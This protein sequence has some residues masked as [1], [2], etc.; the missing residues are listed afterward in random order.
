[1]DTRTHDF[2]EAN[3]KHFNETASDY[4][5]S[6]SSSEL[7]RRIARAVLRRETFDDETTEVMDFAC[8]PGL[9][10]QQLAPHVKSIVGVDISQGMTDIYNSFVSNQ[11][12]PPEE[13]RCMCV[14]LST[15]SPQELQSG[16]DVVICAMAYHHFESIADMTRILT[17]YLKPNGR[18]LVVDLLK[19]EDIDLDV[20]FPEH[21]DNIVAHRGGFKQEDIEEAFTTCG[22]RLEFWPDIAVKKSGHDLRLFIAKG[23]R[24]DK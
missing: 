4:R 23:T 3:R 8:G 16:F 12:I 2:V 7:A 21:K 19:A 15:H 18:L 6:K 5:P 20:I 11:G 1:M 22:L 10:S 13:M 17:S 9:L 14:D 24:E